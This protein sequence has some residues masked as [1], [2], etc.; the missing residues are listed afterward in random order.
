M[1]VHTPVHPSVCTTGK[2]I[3]NVT[4][5]SWYGSLKHVFNLLIDIH[6]MV[7][8]QL[9]NLGIRW[10]ESNECLAGIGANSS[11]S[12]VIKLSAAQLLAFNWSQAQVYV[13]HQLILKSQWPLD[14]W[15]YLQW[16]QVHCLKYFINAE[17][18][19]PLLALP[20]STGLLY[21]TL[22]SSTMTVSASWPA[23][24]I[25]SISFLCW[26]CNWWIWPRL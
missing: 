2:P 17:K 3:W 12:L 4:F 26:S 15:I 8:W 25:S 22:Y 11:R 18:G 9:S 5:S 1:S 20:K 16:F 10:P 21:I 6:F 13:F 24:L 14:L 19:G 7:N 23:F